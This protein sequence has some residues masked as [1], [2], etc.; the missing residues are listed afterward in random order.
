MGEWQALPL[1]MG[2]LAEQRR[3]EREEAQQQQQQ[4]QGVMLMKR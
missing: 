2:E 3:E 1:D 4:Q